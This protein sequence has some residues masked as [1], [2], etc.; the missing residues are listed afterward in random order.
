VEPGSDSRTILSLEYHAARFD[1]INMSL[2]RDTFEEA[3]LNQIAWAAIQVCFLL[4]GDGH[5]EAVRESRT[6]RMSALVVLVLVCSL[7]QALW[8]LRVV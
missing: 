5:I 7:V 1:S 2:G 8:E 3:S 4:C 6:G